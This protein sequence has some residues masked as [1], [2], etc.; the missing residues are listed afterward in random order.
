MTRFRDVVRRMTCERCGNEFGCRRGRSGGCWCGAEP[1][2]LAMPL[3]PE[4]G[5][6]NDCLCPSCLRKVAETLLDAKLAGTQN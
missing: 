2:R 4:A 3:P 1:Y 6:F 5:P